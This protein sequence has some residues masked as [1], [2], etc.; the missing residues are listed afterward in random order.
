MGHAGA[1]ALQLASIGR[2]VRE[3]QL[4]WTGNEVQEP[5]DVPNCSGGL[6]QAP[7]E[8]L[9]PE[10]CTDVLNHGMSENLM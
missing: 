5:S 8:N 3:M 9:I 4:I 7:N 2:S 10:H 1:T 6:Q